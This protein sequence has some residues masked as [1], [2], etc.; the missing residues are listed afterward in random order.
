VSTMDRALCRG[1]P[2]AKEGTLNDSI[3]LDEFIPLEGEH[4][5][6]LFRRSFSSG[7]EITGHPLPYSGGP[8]GVPGVHFPRDT[9]VRFPN[10]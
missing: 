9:K 10:R 7:R 1:N 4:A 2:D 3:R 8:L 5:G 6:K